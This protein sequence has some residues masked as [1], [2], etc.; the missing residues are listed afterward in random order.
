MAKNFTPPQH[1]PDEKAWVKVM[2]KEMD[3]MAGIGT[4]HCRKCSQPLHIMYEKM[5]DQA[6][7]SQ[8]HNECQARYIQEM[9]AQAIQQEM[10][11]RAKEETPNA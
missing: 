1:T 10:I 11:R 8:M 6:R 5:P 3:R 2:S 9:R 7:N 4:L